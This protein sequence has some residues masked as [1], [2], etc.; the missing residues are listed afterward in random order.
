MVQTQALQHWG[1]LATAKSSMEQLELPANLE[2]VGVS[3]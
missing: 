3:S 2:A 1:R